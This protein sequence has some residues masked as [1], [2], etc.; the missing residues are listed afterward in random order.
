MTN[1]RGRTIR[2]C[3]MDSP[4]HL[5]SVSIQ[6]HSNNR[7][8]S[9]QCLPQ[10]RSDA[11]ASMPRGSCVRGMTWVIRTKLSLKSI[12]LAT[13]PLLVDNVIESIYGVLNVRAASAD[14]PL[15]LFTS[16]EVRSKLR[17]KKQALSFICCDYRPKSPY[18]RASSAT[19]STCKE[20]SWASSASLLQ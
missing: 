18:P 11:D 15:N 5:V 4:N 20:Y 19:P 16:V 9:D 12:V 3:V 14:E 17:P 6:P 13:K 2:N 8:V 1:A 7:I 10:F